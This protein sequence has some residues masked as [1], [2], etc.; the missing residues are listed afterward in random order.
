[1]IKKFMMLA[2]GLLAGNAAALTTVWTAGVDGSLPLAK[3]YPY[4]GITTD[5]ATLSTSTEKYNVLTTTVS[6]TNDASVAGVSIDWASKTDVDLSAYK[7]LCLTYKSLK[8]FKLDFKQS[9]FAKTNY[10][11]FGYVVPAQ[12]AVG[13]LFIPFEDLAQEEYWGEKMDLDLTKQ[14]G[15]QISYKQGLAKAASSASNTITIAAIAVGNSCTNA[16]P[17]LGTGYTATV[18]A[19]LIE[20]EAME[21]DLSKIFVDGDGDVLDVKVALPTDSQVVIVEPAKSYSN[22]DVL[23]LA[24]KPNPTNGAVKE[25]VLTA[26]DP[27]GASVTYTLSLTLVDR[28]NT[29]VAKDMAFE[30]LEDSS[31]KN[32]LTTNNLTKLGSDADGD[33]VVF[34][35]VSEPEHGKLEYSVTTGIFTYTPEKDFFGKDYFTYK[36]VEKNDETSESEIATATI[37]VKNVND[38]PVVKVVTKVY[39]DE[40]GKEHAFGDTLTVD[41]DFASFVVSVPKENISIT[42]ADGDDDYTVSAKTSGVATATAVAD[43]DNYLVEVAAKKDSNGTAKVSLTV[44]DPKITIPVDLFVLVVKPVADAPIAKEDSYTVV[45]DSLNKIDAKKGVLANDVNPDGKSALTAVLVVEPEHG[46]LVLAEDGSFTY[47]SAAGYEGEDPFA[48][49]VVNEAGLESEMVIVELNVLHKNHAPVVLA[50]VADTVGN[51]VSDLV[52]DFTTAVNYTIAE[53]KTW[54]ED[55]EGDAFTISARS[56]DSLLKVTATTSKITIT[57]VKDAFGE[58]VIEVIAKDAKGATSVLEIVANL[59]PKNDAPRAARRDTIYVG[60]DWKESVVNL[61]SIFYDPDGD[62][63]TYTLKTVASVFNATIKD[64]KVTVT[65]AEGTKL[66]EKKAYFVVVTAMD[67][68]S[69]EV[70]NSICFILAEDPAAIKTL[71]A[72]PKASWKT[73]VAADRG[74]AVMMDMQGRVMWTRRLPVSESEVRDAAASV[75][76]RKILKVNSQTWTIK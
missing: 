61:D 21:L 47:E 5:K 75:Q 18:D 74:T 25:V 42:D 68:D 17:T 10:N 52:E 48:Y 11:Y 20:G 50:G 57:A 12:S 63:L 73:A 2:A 40:A 24:T 69:S 46:T 65:Q 31:Y 38:A 64:N 36:F 22:S 51:R 7:G 49:K 8:P 58:A 16:K 6:T 3:W 76:G 9:D 14:T 53:A 45:Q 66:Y 27:S 70:S 41:E 54:F 71:V 19:E 34:V 29:P 60:A 26:K 23:T 56:K 33:A 15:I 1:M 43:D 13:A 37:T 44:A 28:N 67:Q 4:T 59:A 30:V 72:A 35:L 55:P 39:L 62:T 32:S